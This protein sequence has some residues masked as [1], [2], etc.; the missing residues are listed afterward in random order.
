MCSRLII[1]GK[2]AGAMMKV[3]QVKTAKGKSADYTTHKED[4]FIID[5]LEEVF[6]YS[7]LHQILPEHGLTSPEIYAMLVLP[8]PLAWALFCPNGHKGDRKV[9]DLKTETAKQ[10]K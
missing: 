8:C 2:R 7:T 4:R 3:G 5:A 9:V 1:S 6:N 10:V